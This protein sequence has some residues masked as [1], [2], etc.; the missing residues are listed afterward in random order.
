MAYVRAAAGRGRVPRVLGTTASVSRLHY[1]SIAAMLSRL[2]G[3]IT[4]R[5]QT[6]AAISPA[7]VTS[8]A[9]L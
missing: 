3:R 9:G 7:G 4:P 8:K 5:S 1:A 2:T 6:I